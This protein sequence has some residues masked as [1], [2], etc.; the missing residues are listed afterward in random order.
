[1]EIVEQVELESNIRELREGVTSDN[2]NDLSVN[3][4]AVARSVAE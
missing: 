2:Y 3:A 4:V 1:M